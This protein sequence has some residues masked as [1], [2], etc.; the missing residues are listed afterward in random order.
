MIFDHHFLCCQ[1]F[2]HI[3]A[4]WLENLNECFWSNSRRWWHNQTNNWESNLSIKVFWWTFE[5]WTTLYVWFKIPASGKI[6]RIFFS[7]FLI[8]YKK[9]AQ[10]TW[11]NNFGYCVC[12]FFVLVFQAG[13]SPWV[14]FLFLFY[15][16]PIFRSISKQD[17]VY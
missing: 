14:A 11:I 1:S 7:V 4:P 12:F 17:Y 6:F 9:I 8:W 2:K 5:V 10:L 15:W 16:T 13:M 3:I